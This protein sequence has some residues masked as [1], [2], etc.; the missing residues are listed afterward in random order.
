MDSKRAFTLIELLVVV[1]IIGILATIVSLNIVGAQEKS[2][3]AK[4]VEQ[5]NT[6]EKAVKMYYADVYDWPPT[7]RSVD[8]HADCNS[9]ED[10]FLLTP[11][12]VDRWNG[13]YIDEGI[14]NMKHPW[15]GAVEYWKDTTAGKLKVVLDDDAPAKASVDNSG[16]I[17]DSALLK[18]DQLIDDGN[19]HTGSA[20][21]STDGG[22]GY[23]GEI[24]HSFVS[25]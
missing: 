2:K 10:P 23:I 11:T 13:P 9:T 5:I 6:V 17:P 24:V 18:I 22:A 8:Y 14:Y 3:V 7:C 12:G 19:L 4:A 1:A 15:G 20:L 25:L 21:Q 16:N